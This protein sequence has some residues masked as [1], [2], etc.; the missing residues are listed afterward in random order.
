[1]NAPVVPSYSR[2]LWVIWLVTRRVMA[3]LRRIAGHY[4]T[5]NEVHGVTLPRRSPLSCEEP[6]FTMAEPLWVM[7]GRRLGKNFLT[8]LQHWSGAVMCPAC[9]CGGQAAGPN[10]MRG[11]GPNQKHAL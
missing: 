8:L 7:C 9:S 4:I 1:M 3:S 5:F 2:T 11:S 6:H 10:A